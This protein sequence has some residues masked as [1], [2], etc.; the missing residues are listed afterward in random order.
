MKRTTYLQF[1]AT[2]Q[3]AKAHSHTLTRAHAKGDREIFCVM[4]GPEANWACCDLRTAI[5][6]EMPYSWSA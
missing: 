6:S 5:E 3:E 2:E 4:A 1:F